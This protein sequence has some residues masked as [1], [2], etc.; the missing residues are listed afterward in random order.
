M[1]KIDELLCPRTCWFGL[2]SLGTICCAVRD[3]LLSSTLV[4]QLSIWWTGI[5]AV[6]VAYIYTFRRNTH[7]FHNL[8]P[9]NAVFSTLLPL[10]RLGV[11]G[12]KGTFLCPVLCFMI[13]YTGHWLHAREKLGNDNIFAISAYNVCVYFILFQMIQISHNSEREVRLL[14]NWWAWKKLVASRFQTTNADED[15]R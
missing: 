5:V 1:S 7:M 2:H 4:V 15:K 3:T 9:F 11:V 12:T 13:C 8:I 10:R 14:K 6:P